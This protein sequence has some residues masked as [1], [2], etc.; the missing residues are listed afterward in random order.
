MHRFSRTDLV[1]ESLV[2]IVYFELRRNLRSFRFLVSGGLLA[3]LV[4]LAV[5]VGLADYRLRVEA[6][7]DKLQ[8]QG[9]SLAFGNVY[10]SLQPIISKK[11]NPLAIFERGVDGQEGTEVRITVVEVPTK[12]T[13]R[14]RGNPYLSRLIGLDVTTV[15]KLVLGLGALLLTF[16]SMVGD[17]SRSRAQVL[18]AHGATPS[19]ILLGKVLAVIGSLVFSLVVALGPAT[20][21]LIAVGVLDWDLRSLA[22]LTGL[23]GAYLAY[24]LTMAL[25]GL[26]ISLRAPTVARSLIYATFAWFILVVLLPLS[27]TA[28]VTA[29]A[30]TNLEPLAVEKEVARLEAQKAFD[31]NRILRQDPIRVET[32]GHRSVSNTVGENGAV[33]RR[34]GSPAFNDSLARYFVEEVRLGRLYAE[35]IHGLRLRAEQESAGWLHSLGWMAA[36]LPGQLLDQMAS[37]MAGTTSADH[38]RFVE[39][40]QTYRQIFLAYLE[41][42]GAVGS[43]R[44]FTD[45]PEQGSPWTTFFGVQPE[46]VTRENIGEAIQRW[47]EEDVQAKV[48]ATVRDR[49]QKD[50]RFDVSDLPV[51]RPDTGEG[52]ARRLMAAGASIIMVGIIWLLV[53]DSARQNR[54][55]YPNAESLRS[56]A[57]SSGGSGMSFSQRVLRSTFRRWALWQRSIFL[58]ELLGIV[59]QLKWRAASVLVIATMM[60]GASVFAIRFQTL[61]ADRDQTQA[62]YEQQLEGTNLA[63]L[64]R[65]HHKLQRPAWSLGFLIDGGERLKPSLYQ[66]PL[67]TWFRPE[68]TIP[69]LDLLRLSTVPSPDWSFV[70]RVV[71]S[72]VTFFLGYD[73]LAGRR[74]SRCR[75]QLAGGASLFRIA[76]S[77]GFALWTALALPFLVGGV[78]GLVVLGLHGLP[79]LSGEEL[80]KLVVFALI[81][82]WALMLYVLLTLVI[83]VWLGTAEKALVTL[84][85]LWI[86][87]VSVIPSAAGILVMNFDPLPTEWQLQADLN[88]IRIQAES[89]EGAG[90]FRRMEW[91]WADGFA[92]EKRAAEI[93][94]QRR[95]EQEALG[96]EYVGRQLAQSEL[97]ELLACLSPMSLLQHSLQ[98]FLGS[99]IYRQYAFIEQARH[100]E[101]RLSLWVREQ[102]SKDPESPHLSFFPRYFSRQPVDAA[103]V[104][105]FEF[106]EPSL[107]EGLRRATLP[108]LILALLTLALACFL[109][110]ILEHRLANEKGRLE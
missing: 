9:S 16:D 39:S 85:L 11:P 64:L 74:L 6:Y 10:S 102:D 73:A 36:I 67:T 104:P 99:G 12:A 100:F 42:K 44:W 83:S 43:W 32:S 53:L 107:I 106:S 66:V 78:L 96:R 59:R 29:I 90:N 72:L 81:G 21:W 95:D 8:E 58:A 68:L 89:K 91:G 27:L 49:L 34:F 79:A 60:I 88:E 75:A 94:R 56:G 47:G 17:H 65:I 48:S 50:P 38:R 55:L 1:S 5:W 24:G 4:A 80:G 62:D 110:W 20:I 69:P 23:F 52:S 54:V 76:V 31:L 101:Q 86:S 37:T 97:A 41:R 63:E 108:L 87:A 22:H 2:V 103:T 26:A 33:L 25:V 35:R 46:E 13:G 92:A 84:I 70:L 7:D 57:G 18:L 105:R 30:D 98:S 82:L 19:E 109:P 15:I 61:S 3:L 93:H 51:F 14:H 40:A 77:K 71:L 45:D 28:G